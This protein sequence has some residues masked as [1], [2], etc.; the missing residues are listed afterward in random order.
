MLFHTGTRVFNLRSQPANQRLFAFQCGTGVLQQLRQVQNICQTPLTTH[1]C[2]PAGGQ[3]HTV[4]ALAQHGQHP[5]SLPHP[6]QVPQLLAVGIKGFVIGGQPC[7]LWQAQAHHAC[8]QTG[9]HHTHI[10]G[11]RNRTQPQQQVLRFVAAEHRLLVRQIDRSHAPALQLMAHS[12]GLTPGAHQ[13]RH[14][15][16]AQALQ[17]LTVLCKPRLGIIQPLHHLLG[18]CLRHVLAQQLIAHRFTLCV[19]PQYVHRG[20]HLPPLHEL[21]FAAMGTYRVKRQGVGACP[22]LQIAEH[23]SARPGPGFCLRKPLVHRLHHCMRG[24]VV[25]IQHIVP[26]LRGMTGAQVA[27]NISPPK[28]INRLLGV[29]NQQQGTFWMV[30]GSAVNAVKQAV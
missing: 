14:I 1:I 26:A 7:Q 24:A 25:H 18:T 22:L 20:H 6:V 2:Q 5:L 12:R 10:Q 17:I 23:E 8:C 30:V 15:A 19:M 27:V 11:G 9:A 4:Q 29:A 28:S 21:L 16:W 3:L 13:Y